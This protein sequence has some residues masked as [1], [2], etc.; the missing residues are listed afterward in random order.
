MTRMKWYLLIQTVICIALAL[1][2]CLSALEICREG[3]ARRAKDPT[4]SIYTP[5]IVA[6]RLAPVAPLFFAS[7]GLLIAGLIFG[8]KDET[9]EK[10]VRSAKNRVPVAAV[11]RRPRGAVQAAL[12]AVAVALILAGILNGSARDVLY[13][14]ITIC[15]ECVGLG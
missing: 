11:R 7:M 13:K 4:Q 8:A 15:T 12:V 2:L 9:A 1:L 5:E 3:A 14:A 10:P 6:E